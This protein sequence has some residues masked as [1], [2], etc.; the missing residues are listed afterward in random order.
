MKAWIE[1][2]LGSVKENTPETL[3]INRIEGFGGWLIGKFIEVLKEIEDTN[4]LYQTF[5]KLGVSEEICNTLKKMDE[6]QKE[7][8][9]VSLE[10]LVSKE[11]AKKLKKDLKKVHELD[12][13][14]AVRNWIDGRLSQK[15]IPLKVRTAMIELYVSLFREYLKKEQPEKYEKWFAAEQG[16]L[17]Q[18]TNVAVHEIAATVVNTNYTVGNIEQSVSDIGKSVTGMNDTVTDM[19]K[20]MTAINETVTDMGETVTGMNHTVTGMSET[21]TSIDESV[22]DMSEKINTIYR[23]TE[24]ASPKPTSITPLTQFPARVQDHAFLHRTKEIEDLRSIIKSNRGAAIVCGLGGIGK[25]TIARRLFH[26]LCEETDRYQYA[27][28]VEYEGS[29][30]ESIQKS[31]ILFEDEQL[32]PEE[33]WA[34]RWGFLRTHADNTLFFIDNINVQV[35][36]D[37]EMNELRKLPATVVLTSR[38][39]QIFDYVPYRVD[40]LETEAA[41]DLFYLY[42]NNSPDDTRGEEE[43]ARIIVEEKVRRH[44]LSVELVAKYARKKISGGAENLKEVLAE[45]EAKNFV[46][47]KDF[48]VWTDHEDKTASVAAQLANLFD[49]STYEPG[50]QR[51]A[52]A[53]SILPSEDIPKAIARCIEAETKDFIEMVELGLLAD[54][55]DAYYMQPVVQESI[56]HQETLTGENGKPK[57]VI[58]VEDCEKLM[59]RFSDND[60]LMELSAAEAYRRASYVEAFRTRFTNQEDVEKRVVLLLHRAI[61]DL[62]Q[63]IGESGKALPYFEDYMRLAGQQVR[64]RQTSGSK[65]E[66]SY[67]Y[68]RVGDA[69]RKLGNPKEALKYDEKA[70]K[71]AEELNEESPSAS[72][73][74]ELSISYNKMGDAYADM[75]NPKE[76]LKYYEKALKLKEELNEESPSASTRRE[77]SISY[78]SMGGYFI[79]LE[80]FTQ[81]LVY[82]HLAEEGLLFVDSQVNSPASRS[83]LETVQRTIEQVENLQLLKSLKEL[84][85]GENLEEVLQSLMEASDSEE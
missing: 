81:A 80:D 73:R 56:R 44:T 68:N 49:I 35:E 58:T 45:L 22:T 82:L 39:M 53:F 72:S 61:G 29:L 40:F 1:D 3:A 17:N 47:P 41:L 65:R 71:L 31:F 48:T 46:Y 37:P 11:A 66:L 63:N 84:V 38:L 18:D 13:P 28:W 74:R 62:Y 51:I 75:R 26:L 14:Q 21:M 30:K 52:K 10:F 32:T 7:E 24:G 9:K 16:E 57:V 76:A 5:Q 43:T 77:L 4:D 69:Y 12:Y 2:L 8:L 55:G 20:T 78:Y 23:R 85:G 59:D 19:G 34:K 67:S 83:E 64:C 70:L 15:S 6:I 50:M 54:Q 79:G 33:R 36:N 42:F 60:F 25:T 27:A